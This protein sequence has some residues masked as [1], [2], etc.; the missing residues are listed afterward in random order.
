M[1]DAIQKKVCYIVYCL[2]HIADLLHQSLISV[3]CL[4]ASDTLYVKTT[5]EFQI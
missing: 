5:E 2:Y 3:W 4:T 1:L